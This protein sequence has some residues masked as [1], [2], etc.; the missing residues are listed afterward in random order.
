MHSRS[1]GLI[2][3]LTNSSLVTLMNA[4][5][6]F[7]FFLHFLFLK[8]QVFISHRS[9]CVP[10]LAQRQHVKLLS[11]NLLNSMWVET[12]S[13]TDFHRCENKQ[14]QLTLKN[15]RDTHF[16][17]QFSSNSQTMHVRKSATMLI[18][19]LKKLNLKS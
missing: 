19:V 13:N 5:N 6:K 8:S 17:Y 9:Y 11:V 2:L 18:L 15:I 4:A 16:S 1:V 7:D 10:T 3:C 14:P 12:E